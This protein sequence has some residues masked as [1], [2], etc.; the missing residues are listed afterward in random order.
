[1]Q[2]TIFGLFD[3][4]PHAHLALEDLGEAGFTKDHIS[5]LGKESVLKEYSD[6]YG[7]TG[8]NTGAT[9]GAIVG[10]VLG[11]IAAAA[12]FPLPGIGPVIG[13]GTLM[14]V[15]GI[16]TAGAGLG[17]L[18]GG[19]AGAFV[20]LGTDEE[21]AKRYESGIQEGHIL[22]AVDADE[23]S[24]SVAK[25]ILERHGARDIHVHSP[26]QERTRQRVHAH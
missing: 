14:S 3:N 18:A 19:L 2:Q 1:M 21:F 12:A 17:A 16:T 13:I 15:L 7:N 24:I 9:G 10:G 6:E 8:T 22:L 26:V 4:R 25:N 23:T 5:L 11:L 20:D